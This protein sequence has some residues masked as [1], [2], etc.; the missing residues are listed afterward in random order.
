MAVGA[1]KHKIARLPLTT[2]MLPSA[3]E[4]LDAYRASKGLTRNV[5]LERAIDNLIASGNVAQAIVPKPADPLVVLPEDLRDEV[6][7]FCV[8]NG[9]AAE[10]LLENV[11]R[12]FMLQARSNAPGKA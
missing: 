3:I 1:K 4:K 11:L 8:A 6:L 12:R 10:A 7:T 5:V 9:V 2:T